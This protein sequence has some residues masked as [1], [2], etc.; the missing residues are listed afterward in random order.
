MAEQYLVRFWGEDISIN[1]TWEMVIQYT[2]NKCFLHAD[3]VDAGQC[4]QV[5]F[6]F[7]GDLECQETKL[8]PI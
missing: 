5:I 6:S 4:P 7:T 2:F 1:C 8:C 3:Y